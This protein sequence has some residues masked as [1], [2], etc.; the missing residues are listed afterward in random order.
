MTFI[1]AS[2]KNTKNYTQAGAENLDATRKMII[3]EKCE[4]CGSEMIIKRGK[5]GKFLACSQYPKCK[6]AKPISIG[7]K[8]PESNCNG[9]L[10]ERRARYKIFYGC[11]NYPKCKFALWDKPINKSCPR[12]N[13]PFLIE[14]SER[15]T[16]KTFYKCNN[17][18]C[19]YIEETS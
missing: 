4:K 17:K 2:F 10:V 3:D 5:Y 16:K 1:F 18:D 12:C 7:V 13:A 14:K 15:K 9:L 11:S 8:C 6:F 19:E